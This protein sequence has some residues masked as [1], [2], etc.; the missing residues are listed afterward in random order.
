MVL[1]NAPSRNEK[2][3]GPSTRL[4]LAVVSVNTSDLAV[5]DHRGSKCVTSAKQDLILSTRSY[6]TNSSHFL[7]HYTSLADVWNSLWMA[8]NEEL[9]CNGEE[10]ARE[11]HKVSM[12]ELL[13]YSWLSIYSGSV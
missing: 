3:H 8:A 11:S 10:Y 13:Q 6:H 9:P 4:L 2:M 1:Y 5:R 7:R 12:V